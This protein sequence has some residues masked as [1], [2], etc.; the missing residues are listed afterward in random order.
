MSKVTAQPAV[1]VP[2]IINNRGGVVGGAN[3]NGGT[4]KIASPKYALPGT[5][6]TR[7]SGVKYIPVA[8]FGAQ[9]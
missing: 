7:T 8:P 9:A 6:L 1:Y 3:D 2:G 4:L 5:I